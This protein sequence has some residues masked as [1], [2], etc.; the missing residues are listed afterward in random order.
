MMWDTIWIRNL[1]F[2]GTCGE[3]LLT[4]IQALV[5]S[6]VRYTCSGSHRFRAFPATRFQLLGSE[7][8]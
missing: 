4:I 5:S 8:G 1:I 7:I 2:D 6:G 3:I